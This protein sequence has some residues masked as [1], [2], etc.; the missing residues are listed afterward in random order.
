MLLGTEYCGL[1]Q[2][3]FRDGKSV[4]EVVS[5]EGSGYGERDGMEWSLGGG[6]LIWL[7]VRKRLR[8][9]CTKSE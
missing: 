9:R 8:R 5:G 3:R 2:T 1:G 4:H 6:K 7:L